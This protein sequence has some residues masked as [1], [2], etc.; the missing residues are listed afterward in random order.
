M[1]QPD[2][3]APA[4]Q[5]VSRDEGVREIKP[6]T[7]GYD[8]DDNLY[9]FRPT[10]VDVEVPDPK[11]SSAAGSADFSAL[12]AD[13]IPD[14]DAPETPT[15]GT[16]PSPAAPPAPPASVEKVSTPPKASESSKQTS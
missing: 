13:L 3:I 7:F 6:V 15:P 9:D 10:P 16:V 5:P 8:E 4:T 1:T 14:P 11:D 12:E 2:D